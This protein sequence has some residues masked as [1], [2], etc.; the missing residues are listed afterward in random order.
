MN[1]HHQ[2]RIDKYYQ[3]IR[4]ARKTQQENPTEETLCYLAG[5]IDALH[6]ALSLEGENMEDWMYNLQEKSKNE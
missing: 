3:R 4:D 1:Y 5:V 2:Q 6:Y